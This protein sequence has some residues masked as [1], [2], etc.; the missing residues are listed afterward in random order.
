MADN[1]TIERLTA[2]VKE[3]TQL[4]SEIREEA[5]HENNAESGAVD[6]GVDNSD[7]GVMGVDVYPG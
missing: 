5:R 3:L 7:H 6:S 2:A 1:E 4:I